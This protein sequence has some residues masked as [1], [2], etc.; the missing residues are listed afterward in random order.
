MPRVEE[1]SADL[2]RHVEAT[3][4]SL[5]VGIAVIG[6]TLPPVLWL[7]GLSAEGLSLL[8]S[9]SAYYHTGM[10]NVFVG[11]LCAVGVALFLYKGFSKAED[12]SL[13]LAGTLAVCV[14]LFPTAADDQWTSI[15]YVHVIAAVGFFLCLAYV[16]VFRAADTL[17]LVRDARRARLLEKGYRILGVAMITSPVFALVAARVL[18]SPGNES[19]LVFYLEAF[20]VWAFAAY[21]LVKSWELKQTHADR[22]AAQ[23]L[24]RAFTTTKQIS[25]PGRLLQIAPFPESFDEPRAEMAAEAKVFH[26]TQPGVAGMRVRRSKGR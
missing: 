9:M 11:T 5:R 23:G 8:G 19:S 15:N 1:S 24:L 13:S 7:G 20:G 4:L 12:Y 2:Q 3:Y 6:A 25:V 26:S 10:R 17:L 14:A 21:W 16:S 22:A 18:S